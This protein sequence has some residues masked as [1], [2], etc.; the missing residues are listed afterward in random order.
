MSIHTLFTCDKEYIKKA[1]RLTEDRNLFFH[2]HLSESLYEPAWSVEKYGKRPVEV[3][4]EIDILIKNQVS[5]IHMPLS[6]CEVGGGIAPYPELIKK[7]G[8]VGL[9]THG[10]INN[11]FEVMLG[12]FN[13]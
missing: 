12:A 2:M 9:G 1:R 11:F 3:Y 5:M 4:E 13:P 6:N 8:K 10:Y 7:G